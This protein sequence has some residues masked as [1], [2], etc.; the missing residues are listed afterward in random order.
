MGRTGIYTV[1]LFCACL[2][3]ALASE[4]SGRITIEK[5]GNTK[6]VAPAVYDLRG[7]ALSSNAPVGKTSSGYERV[8]I[9]LESNAPEPAPAVKA[10]MRQRNQHLDPDLLVVPVGSTVDFPNLDPI[11]HNIFSLSRTQSFDLGY[12]AE[13]R[14][15]SIS[16]PH[17]G[18]V[19]VYC[20]VHPNMHAVII[21][22]ASRWFGKPASDGAFSWSNVPA[23]NYRMCVWQKSAGVVRRKIVV[24]TTGSLRVDM[25]IPNEDPEN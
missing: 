8:G 24:P 19:Q 6:L 15:R 12:Y 16:F 13:G 22:A 25:S 5:G 10:E 3:H 9:W 7:V 2:P 20:H 11:F 1:A 18:I 14:S 21:I 4:I 23:G 17:A